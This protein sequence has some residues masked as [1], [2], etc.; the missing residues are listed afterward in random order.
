MSTKLQYLIIVV[1]A[2]GFFTLNHYNNKDK[3][4]EISNISPTEI[5]K[6]DK[7]LTKITFT[8]AKGTFS[9]RR[10]ISKN[11][12][13]AHYFSQGKNVWLLK[14]KAIIKTSLNNYRSYDFVN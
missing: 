12:H 2:C 10:Y 9:V 11:V 13:N 1:L 3:I 8:T 14:D 4:S 7:T 5:L 6:S